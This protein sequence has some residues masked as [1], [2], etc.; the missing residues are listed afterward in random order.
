MSSSER[1]AIANAVEKLE[2]FGPA[3]PFP[4][5]SAVKGV[6][7]LRE[8]RPRAGRSQW[9]PLYRRVTESTFV[10]AA[11]A[12]EAETNRRGFRKSIRAAERRL[13]EIEV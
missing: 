13:D 5:Q 4:H 1:V 3:L 12:P 2:E 6:A 7:E 11:I 10:I 8:L 9:R